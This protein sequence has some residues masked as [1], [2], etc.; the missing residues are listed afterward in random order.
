[1]N[2][3]RQ[4]IG[5][6]FRDFKNLFCRL[7]QVIEFSNSSGEISSGESKTKT[8]AVLSFALVLPAS[9]FAATAFNIMRVMS[10]DFF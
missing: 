4:D 9:S 2:S 6:T 5:V 1:M 3:Q 8:P 10:S 7:P